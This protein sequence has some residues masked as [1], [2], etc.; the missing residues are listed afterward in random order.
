[1][2]LS[3]DRNRDRATLI[4]SLTEPLSADGGELAEL[5]AEV[6]W[7]EV[8][9]DL[10]GEVEPDWLRE[11][12]GGKKLLYTLRSA[13][14]GGASESS[15]ARRRQ[16]L[17]AA[18]EAG[19]DL[20]D[21][22]AARDLDRSL[23]ERIPEERRLLSWHGR[24]RHLQK[25]R[26]RFDQMA[27]V[28]ARLYK[29]IPSAEA[30]GEELGAAGAS[31]RARAPGRG[32]LRVGGDRDL[33]PTGGAPGGCPRGLRLGLHQARGA[34]PALGRRAGGR[35][36]PA[37]AGPG[38][39]RLRHRGPAGRGFAVATP[40]QRGLPRARHRGPL[41]AVPRRELRRV[42]AR[43]GREGRPFRSWV[44]RSAACR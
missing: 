23:L 4:A 15:P 27:E 6:E 14:E 38:A 7:L 21:L 39:Q 26:R 42:L 16:R 17:G 36:R 13:A 29:L 35:L 22:E 37:K 44:C 32:E 3:S 11:K 30:P 25:L 33:D 20:I 41:P 24:A 34:R 19:Y 10:V 8:R 43:G 5:P 18:V 1:M 31:A 28:P 2:D 12:S 40:P 9:A